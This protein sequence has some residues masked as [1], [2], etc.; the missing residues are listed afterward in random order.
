MYAS[1]ILLLH[2]H[3]EL[4]IHDTPFVCLELVCFKKFWTSCFGSKEMSHIYHVHQERD[5]VALRNHRKFIR[6]LLDVS[7]INGG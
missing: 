5:A 3:N 6:M 1:P 4:E 2:A 7:G